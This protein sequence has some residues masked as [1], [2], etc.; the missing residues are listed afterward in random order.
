[1]VRRVLLFFFGITLLLSGCDKGGI[2]YVPIRV[3]PPD[4]AAAISL[5]LDAARLDFSRGPLVT[6][7]FK[8]GRLALK[9]VDSTWA[10]TICSILVRKDRISA[11]TVVAG[12]YPPRCVCE[13]RAPESDA[14]AVVCA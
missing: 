14:N 6:L 9:S 11:L 1:M 8:T 10:P 3:S 2:G 4:A 12:R 13:I 5:Y 7:Q